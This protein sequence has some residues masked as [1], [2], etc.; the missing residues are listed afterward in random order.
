MSGPFGPIHTRVVV[1][2]TAFDYKECS[3]WGNATIRTVVVGE[4]HSQEPN[5]LPWTTLMTVNQY[6]MLWFTVIC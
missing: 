6:R 1:T 3:Q 5:R 4:V 2:D